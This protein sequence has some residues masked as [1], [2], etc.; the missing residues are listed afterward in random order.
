MADIDAVLGCLGELPQELLAATDAARAV[1]VNA[2]TAAT[3]GR[4]PG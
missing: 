2:L 4:L 3:N 1:S